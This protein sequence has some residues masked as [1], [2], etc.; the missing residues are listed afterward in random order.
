M[1]NSKHTNT[2]GKGIGQGYTWQYSSLFSGENWTTVASEA[3][4]A[5][6]VK[7][8]YGSR[9]D[10]EPRSELHAFMVF[11]TLFLDLAIIG[12]MLLTRRR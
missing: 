6:A 1:N 9:S 3:G 7:Q 5:S 8:V 11:L 4:I 12:V 10:S 2:G